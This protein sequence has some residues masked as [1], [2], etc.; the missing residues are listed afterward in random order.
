[1][2]QVNIFLVYNKFDVT[3]FVDTFESFT[4]K[5]VFEKVKLS[6]PLLYLYLNIVGMQ[7]QNTQL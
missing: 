6:Q 2:K 5:I 1:M 7:E 4:M 3:F